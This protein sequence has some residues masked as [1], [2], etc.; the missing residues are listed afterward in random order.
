MSSASVTRPVEDDETERHTD[1]VTDPNTGADPER[2]DEADRDPAGD[3]KKSSISM[4]FLAHSWMAMKRHRTRSHVTKPY[5]A[6]SSGMTKN[7]AAHVTLAMLCMLPPSL[8]KSGSAC[9]TEGNS[10]APHPRANWLQL[11]LSS[12]RY[13]KRAPCTALTR[14]QLHHDIAVKPSTPN[15]S[16]RPC[17][18]DE[19]GAPSATHCVL[20]QDPDAIK[21]ARL[22]EKRIL[23]IA[24]CEPRERGVSS[25]SQ[26]THITHIQALPITERALSINDAV[27]TAG[28]MMTRVIL[29]FVLLAAPCPG[30]QKRLIACMAGKMWSKGVNLSA[31]LVAA[32]TALS[33]S[34]QV[35][36]DDLNTLCATWA[37]AGDCENNANWMRATC[38]EACRTN[39]LKCSVWTRAGE[40]DS[41]PDFMWQRCHE[42]CTQSGG[43]TSPRKIVAQPNSQEPQSGA[44]SA[45]NLPP[46]GVLGAS[47]P[48]GGRRCED[49]DGRCREW[50]EAGECFVNP[51]FMGVHCCHSCTGDGESGSRVRS[52]VQVSSTGALQ[53]ESEEGK[54]VEADPTERAFRRLIATDAQAAGLARWLRSA[55]FV[56][57]PHAAAYAEAM[58][59]D[60]VDSESSLAT[61]AR[62]DPA[63]LPGA[64]QKRYQ[65]T[66][67]HALDI[68]VALSHV[69]DEASTFPNEHSNA[70]AASA[71]EV[72]SRTSRKLHQELVQGKPSTSTASQ[73]KEPDVKEA[74]ALADEEARGSWSFYQDA[75]EA[76]TALGREDAIEETIDWSEAVRTRM[77]E[78]APGAARVQTD[79]YAALQRDPYAAL[80]VSD[81]MWQATKWRHIGPGES[82]VQVEIAAPDCHE[83][84]DERCDEWSRS[85]KCGA[86]PDFMT[87][88]SLG[89]ALPIAGVWVSV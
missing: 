78:D 65:I 87:R 67:E 52:R 54:A 68:M 35:G 83:D 30:S 44:P 72:P 77:A 88:V 81:W 64:L 84:R 76:L 32:S 49:R 89:A 69:T 53:T 28:T 4:A 41:N 50:F 17:R 47:A 8:V 15:T 11:S 45:T 46:F 66:M 26:D 62:L 70:V 27:A 74:K 59:R 48:P 20:T 12:E 71:N 61:A 36:C 43:Q 5:A 42:S 16:A 19:S 29:Q 14:Q 80:R 75:K 79:P 38:C 56:P 24:R 25:S 60:G 7:R 21:S 1:P 85:G 37:D 86:N 58:S 51:D 23:R 39:A 18:T 40:C 63:G 10:D 73:K 3:A 55:A 2:R 33:P 9:S 82:G 31:L 22:S 13:E 57:A 6:V 34:A